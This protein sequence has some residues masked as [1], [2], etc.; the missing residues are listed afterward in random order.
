MTKPLILNYAIPRKG[1]FAPIYSYDNKK[2][3]NTIIVNN[4]SIAFIDSTSTDISFLTK[5]RVKSE[6]DEDGMNLL[7]LGTKTEVI[8]ER[9]DKHV[10]LLE[11][12]TKT[13]VK[14]E[15]DD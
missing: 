11:L 5:T 6:A 9:D 13:L 2:S 14:Q 4:T 15:S 12:Q 10:S 8:R 1:E 7:E 3:L